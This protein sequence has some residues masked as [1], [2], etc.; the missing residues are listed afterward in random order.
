MKIELKKNHGVEL[1]EGYT[2]NAE[3]GVSTYSANNQRQGK[4]KQK[5]DKHHDLKKYYV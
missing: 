4:T 2:A 1:S 3:E 5:S